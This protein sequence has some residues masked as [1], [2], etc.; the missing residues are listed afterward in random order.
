MNDCPVCAE[1]QAEEREQ[2]TSCEER[3][4]QSDAKSQRLSV[5][6]AVV[7]TLVAKET[8]DQALGIANGVDQAAAQIAGQTRPE[9][10]PDSLAANQTAARTPAQSR[11]DLLAENH[12]RGPSSVWPP[13][14]FFQ[15]EEQPEA[16]FPALPPLLTGLGFDPWTPMIQL[17]EPAANLIPEPT[18]LALILMSL[19]PSRRRET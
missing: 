8:L 13:A 9:R 19:K 16:L 17:P 15:F 1:R 12:S 2:L 18:G 6:L 4:K 3:C 14:Q 7:S 11:P 5:V 10:G